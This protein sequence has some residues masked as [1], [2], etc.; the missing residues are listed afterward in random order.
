MESGLGGEREGLFLGTIGLGTAENRLSRLCG[1]KR[2][3]FRRTGTI[4]HT[5]HLLICHVD[6]LLRSTHLS[7]SFVLLCLCDYRQNRALFGNESL[8]YSNIAEGVAC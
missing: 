4:F 7:I 1:A 5:R 3:D 6:R 8:Y 2:Y